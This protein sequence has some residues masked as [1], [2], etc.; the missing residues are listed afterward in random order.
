MYMRHPR[1]ASIV[2]RALRGLYSR[3]HVAQ[4]S[5]LLLHVGDESLRVQI[6]V[7]DITLDLFHDPLLY[8]EVIVLL[9]D[10]AVQL[11]HLGHES[12]AESAVQPCH[13]VPVVA[14]QRRIDRRYVAHIEQGVE[15]Q[16]IIRATKDM[17]ARI[18]RRLVYPQQM[19]QRYIRR[20]V[21]IRILHQL[22]AE[23]L[24]VELPQRSFMHHHP[25]RQLCRSPHLEAHFQALPIPHRRLPIR[26]QAH[27]YPHL[28]K[29]LL[30]YPI[31]PNHLLIGVPFLLCLF[32]YDHT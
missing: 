11:V 29:L 2:L 10:I 21:P 15:Q 32:C 30:R 24:V 9:Y 3:G 22:Q 4:W 28:I 7:D 27:P 23:E 20:L 14:R 5:P 13:L 12:L 1:G 17:D 16:R 19:A 31:C 6:R 26:K 18:I 25:H 8:Q